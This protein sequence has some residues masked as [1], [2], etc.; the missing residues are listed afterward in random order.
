MRGLAIVALLLGA[1]L[2]AGIGLATSS[3]NRGTDVNE[4]HQLTA[5]T[6]LGNLAPVGSTVELECQLPGEA[7]YLAVAPVTA[8]SYLV[9]AVTPAQL[10]SPPR[11]PFTESCDQWQARHH[12]ATAS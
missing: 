10:D 9:V 8:F 5:L 3:A 2:F 7:G 6:D 1:C 11:G 4:S 12:V